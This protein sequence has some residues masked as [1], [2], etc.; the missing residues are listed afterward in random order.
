MRQIGFYLM[1]ATLLLAVTSCTGGRAVTTEADSV[2][3]PIEQVSG[4]SHQFWGLWQFV[5][6][7]MKKTLD[8]IPL[9]AGNFH[10]NALT[11]L[12]PPPLVNVTLESLEFNGDIIE[13]G[14]GLRHPFIGL[15]EFTGFDV[16]GIFIT[17]GSVTGFSDSGLR[18]AG[19]GDTRLLNP[20]GY[21][22]WWN[23]AEFPYGNTMFNYKDGLLGTP[24]AIGNY[25][26]TL[27]AYKYFCDDLGATDTLDK[28][29][30]AKRGMFS[31]GHK[32]IRH[33]TIETGAGLIFN[34]AVDACWVFPSGNPPYTAPDDFSS[35]ANRPEAWRIEVTETANT[36]WNDGS[37]SGGDLILSIDIYDWYNVTQNKVKVE[38]PGNFA[39]VASTTPTGGGE[40]YATYEVEILNA[41]PAQGSISLLITVES[42]NIGY[43]GLLPGKPVTA[44]FTRAVAVGNEPPITST[45]WARTWGGSNY[46]EGRNVATDSFGNVYVTGIF[47]GTTDFDPGDGVDERTS[48]DSSFDVYL[49][50]YNTD[51]EYQW[52]RAWGGPNEDVSYG[53]ATDSSGNIYVS[54]GFTG[55]VDFD[56]GE[57]TN[58][59]STKT[60]YYSDP[61]VTKFD[62]AGS[63]LWAR[64]W[65]G[66]SNDFS[67]NVNTDNSDNVYV[68]GW[69][70][71]TSADFN[72]DGGDVQYSNGSWDVF[73]SKF[74]SEGSYQW[75]R[76]WGGGSGD[77]GYAVSIDNTGDIYVTGWFN[78]TVDFDPGSG[79]DERTSNGYWDAYLSKLDSA[80]DYVWA[81]TWGDAEQDIGY[82]TS[83]DNSGNVY[84]SGAF[85]GTVDF[86]PGTGILNQTSK[87][88][89]D[90]YLSKFDSSGAFQWVRT[91]GGSDYDEARCLASDASGNAF[92]AGYFRGTVDFDTGTGVD[93]KTSKGDL[94]VF[95]SKFSP[96]GDFLWA[97]TWGG[98]L[99]DE[100]YGV[101]ADMDGNSYV[102]GRFQGTV[103]FD[104]GPDECNLDSNGSYDAFLSKFLPDGS[105]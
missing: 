4:S 32:N 54:G 60:P 100:G 75:A 97:K 17:N 57:G 34:Y 70:G 30:L 48:S 103:D 83:V 104:P 81:V 43:G 47:R 69:F 12:E 80:G 89:N 11:F 94:D 45:G 1:I 64:S 23:P 77:M 36:L 95:L 76:T 62:S 3:P 50:K 42:E 84:V 20:D 52:A 14:I 40:G 91:W 67:L 44:Y 56:P 53:I 16:C 98:I 82:D 79:T 51:G 29:T 38:S 25:N 55:T 63:H 93:N 31:A 92:T 26:S 102:T 7:P 73:L 33:Y 13:A 66:A 59:K 21:S 22:R 90:A 78:E 101:D 10:L 87:G 24:D 15:T 18:M 96:S 35:G 8:V 99:A 49:V 19:T 5:A 46:E 41:T 6:D 37:S 68:V 86:D 28:V 9:R 105:W 39:P 85:S 58:N 61:Y 72:P 2:T 71:S 88:S 74:D 65:G 27:N